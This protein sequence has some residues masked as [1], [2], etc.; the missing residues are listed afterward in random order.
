MLTWSWR[1][2]SLIALHRRWQKKRGWSEIREVVFEDGAS[3]GCHP[4]LSEMLTV[5][6]SVSE[7]QTGLPDVTVVLGRHVAQEV[8]WVNVRQYCTAHW[9]VRKALYKCCPFTICIQ[10]HEIVT[11]TRCSFMLYA[12]ETALIEM[13]VAH[14][15]GQGA[16]GL[17][18]WSYEI[19][20]SWSV[21]LKC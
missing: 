11:R 18:G 2:P 12:T 9:V 4:R 15:S 14:G 10:I 13:D 16:M 20:F 6:W 8:E 17:F 19:V 3:Y 1:P 21:C 7:V 5:K